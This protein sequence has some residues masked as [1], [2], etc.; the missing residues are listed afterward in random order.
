MS[1]LWIEFS[2]GILI[3]MVVSGL[4]ERSTQRQRLGNLDDMIIKIITNE[5][6]K[7]GIE[8]FELESIVSLDN[9][10]TTCVIAHLDH[11]EIA[12]EVNNTTGKIIHKERLAR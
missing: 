9:T 2:A 6:A 10:N 11:T 5:L 7:D 4:L 3:M 1:S 8:H 12:I